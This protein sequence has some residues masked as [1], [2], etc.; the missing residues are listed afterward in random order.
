M[1]LSTLRSA[2]KN[3]PVRRIWA[4]AATAHKRCGK[5]TLSLFNGI[6]HTSAK[7]GAGPTDYLMFA[8]YDLSEAERATYLTRIR[9]AA[10]V[11]RVN[12][13]AYSYIFNDKNTFYEKFGDLMGREVCNLSTASAEAFRTFMEKR[14]AIIAKPVDG[15]CGRGIEKLYKKDFATVDE[16]WTYLRQPDK[17][18]G[19]AEEV[20]RQHPQAARLHPDS[21]NCI[22]VATFVVDGTAHVIYAACKAGTGGAAC[23]NTGRGGITCR[24]DLDAGVIC[25]NGHDE[26]ANEYE[27]HPTTGVTL[28]GFP[29]P[30]HEEV[31]AL[32]LQA[33]LRYPDF[34]YV[35][36]DICVT[37]TGPVI[38]EGNDYPGYDLAQMPDRDEP[39]PRQG[40]IPRFTALG[41]QV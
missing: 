11:K 8:F 18:F 22:R 39:H 3:V 23:D 33:A 36:W 35:G 20:L 21:V 16:M 5:P 28:K 31:K 10:L 32:A 14:E 40:L 13:R 24:F 27:T 7:Y 1:K 29:M 6:L 17:G 26:E 41:I 30:M 12:D 37:E 9:S 4:A 25:A 38:I 15:D 2:A 19:I 34:R